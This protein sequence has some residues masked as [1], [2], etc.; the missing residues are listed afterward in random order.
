MDIYQLGPPASYFSLLE[1]A[2]E[3]LETEDNQHK[4]G[5]EE[6]PGCFMKSENIY[7]TDSI[8]SL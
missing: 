8:I 1:H 7:S 6:I 5:W 3:V 2:A 4:R